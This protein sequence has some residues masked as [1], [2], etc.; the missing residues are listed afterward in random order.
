MNKSLMNENGYI[1]SK[2]GNC[3]VYYKPETTN[4]INQHNINLSEIGCDD[5]NNYIELDKDEESSA[6][7]KFDHRR[8]ID[9]HCKDLC[10]KN[11]KVVI[12]KS[13]SLKFM[14]CSGLELSPVKKSAKYDVVL[15][16]IKV[17]PT[18]CDSNND[19]CVKPVSI[20]VPRRQ[21][22]TEIGWIGIKAFGDE[23]EKI[24]YFLYPIRL[25]KRG[26][27]VNLPPCFKFTRIPKSGFQGI[28][29]TEFHP[30]RINITV[31]MVFFDTLST[32]PS[33]FILLTYRVDRDGNVSLVH[34]GVEAEA[35]VG[36]GGS[37][38]WHEISH[39]FPMDVSNFDKFYFVLYSPIP[40]SVTLPN[41]LLC[42]ED[43]VTTKNKI[44]IWS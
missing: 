11:G 16:E 24:N 40:R 6:V 26:N 19:E 10:Y 18:K 25:Y 27:F 34:E 37:A 15:E 42:L 30:T 39:T 13:A 38:F 22:I 20:Y 36:T 8:C 29:Y 7:D 4:E 3:V 2:N 35:E 23:I 1:S 33:E 5:C 44:I 9:L 14:K 21:K 32:V 28:E 43:T 12:G 17:C 41:N 31:V